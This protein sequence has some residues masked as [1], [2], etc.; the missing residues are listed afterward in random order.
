MCVAGGGG[1]VEMA[2][3]DL[4]GTVAQRKI[5]EIERT[6]ADTVVTSCQR[7]MRTIKSRL[8]R[9]KLNLNLMDI[10]ELVLQAMAS[11]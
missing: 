4:S 7:C 2:D 10:R 8:R 9:Q 3:S 6:G 11:H 1:N 5:E